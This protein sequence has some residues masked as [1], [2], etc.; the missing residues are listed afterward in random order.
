[1]VVG[2]SFGISMIKGLWWR[3]ESEDINIEWSIYKY[4][5]EYEYIYKRVAGQSQNVAGRFVLLT[6]DEYSR[7]E[8]DRQVNVLMQ[9]YQGDPTLLKIESWKVRCF[10]VVLFEHLHV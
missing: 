2:Y 6:T 10:F 4:E 1:M 8:D 9:Y 7:R 5:Y 3:V